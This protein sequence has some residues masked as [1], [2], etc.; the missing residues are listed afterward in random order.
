VFSFTATIMF[1]DT[2]STISQTSF[3]P[4]NGSFAVAR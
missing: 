1:G 4:F 3:F 2:P